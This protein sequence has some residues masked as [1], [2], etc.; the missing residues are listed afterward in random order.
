MTA[1]S[2]NEPTLRQ[3]VQ[4]QATAVRRLQTCLKGLFQ[5]FGTS[6]VKDPGAIDGDFGPN[7]RASV[8]SFQ[9]NFGSGVADGV[10]GPITWSQLDTADFRFPFGG[11]DLKSGDTG[12]PVRHL[13]RKLFEAA[14]DPGAVDGIYGNNT[15]AAVRDFQKNQGLPQNGAAGGQTRVLLSFVQ[16]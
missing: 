7:T 4:G 1:C 11:L 5:L 16:G 8:V 14:S 12:N 10:V 13:Q 3:G 15:Q 6:I 9:T 2:F